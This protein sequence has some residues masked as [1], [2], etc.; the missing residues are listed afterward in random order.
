MTEILFGVL[1]VEKQTY[2]QNTNSLNLAAASRFDYMGFTGKKHCPEEY[3]NE[4]GQ[5][6]FC[7]GSQPCAPGGNLGGS[8]ASAW[9]GSCAVH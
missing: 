1:E 9:R 5:H 2:V 6:S 3:P 7:R 8:R 4:S